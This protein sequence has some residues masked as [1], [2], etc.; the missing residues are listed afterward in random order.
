M[1]PG[2]RACRLPAV[3]AVKA[4]GCCSSQ[5]RAASST[6]RGHLRPALR[7]EGPT[8]LQRSGWPESMLSGS[9]VVLA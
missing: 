5:C 3:S 8:R 1:W 9:A 2:V 6:T 4:R 7:C